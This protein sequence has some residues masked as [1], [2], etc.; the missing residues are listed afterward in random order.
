[1]YI[2]THI[3]QHISQLFF[4]SFIYLYIHTHTSQHQQFEPPT[5]RQWPG[6]LGHHRFALRCPFVRPRSVA[7]TALSA[8]G[9]RLWRVFRG[10]L[11]AAARLSHGGSGAKRVEERADDVKTDENKGKLETSC[12][13]SH[14]VH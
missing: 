14:F 13:F 10:A 12:R 11:C 6:P 9:L 4:H 1:M 8:R 2:Y 5:W 3:N 7:S